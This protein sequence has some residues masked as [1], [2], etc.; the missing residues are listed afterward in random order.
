VWITQEE[1]SQLNK[2]H[3]SWRPSNTYEQL[4]IKIVSHG[5]WAAINKEK[6]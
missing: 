4:G 2:M 6:T 3:R 5:V 1:D